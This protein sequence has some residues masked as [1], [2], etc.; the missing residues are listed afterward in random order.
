MNIKDKD[1]Q[2]P[3]FRELK[4][5]ADC[6][7]YVTIPLGCGEWEDRCKKYDINVDEF[8]ICDDFIDYHDERRIR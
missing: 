4:T 5:C 8:C 2:P 7:Y 1:I 3:N 6:K